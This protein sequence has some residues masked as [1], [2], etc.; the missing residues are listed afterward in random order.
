MV[1]VGR[2]ALQPRRL[3]GHV[4][5]VNGAGTECGSQASVEPKWLRIVYVYSVCVHVCVCVHGINPTNAQMTDVGV[6]G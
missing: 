5:S 3:V 1:S 2:Q 6:E 4:K